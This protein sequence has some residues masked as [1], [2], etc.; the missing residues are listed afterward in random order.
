MADQVF[1]YE[2]N[3]RFCGYRGL[4]ILQIGK[5]DLLSIVSMRGIA[6]APGFCN[7]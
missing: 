3:Q 1:L 4:L 6:T 5:H 7:N 2:P